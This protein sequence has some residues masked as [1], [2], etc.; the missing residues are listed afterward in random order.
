M[1]LTKAERTIILSMWGKISTQADA[2]GTEALERLFASFPQTKT[3]F[4]HF[5]LRAGSAHLRAHGAKVVAALGDAV[6]SLD[7][8]AGALSRLSEL[9]AYILRVDPVN[10]KLLSHCL[11]VTLASHFP[12]DLTADAHAAWDKFLSLVSCV[13]T[14]KYR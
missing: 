7:D 6:R 12:A 1:S 11:L 8:V 4:P 10:F 13:L 9:H 5:E 2:I 14:E 3:Y